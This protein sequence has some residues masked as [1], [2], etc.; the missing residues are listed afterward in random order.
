MIRLTPAESNECVY[1]KGSIHATTALS[2]SVSRQLKIHDAYSAILP[3]DENIA[4]FGVR[5]QF[6]ALKLLE[7]NGSS[8]VI[9]TYNCHGG[10]LKITP[11]RSPPLPS[12]LCPISASRCPLHNERWRKVYSF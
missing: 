11:L 2:W 5:N 12:P 9:G 1:L 7:V 4:S 3:A 10:I 6:H 8:A